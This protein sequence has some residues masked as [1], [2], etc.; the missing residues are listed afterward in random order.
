MSIVIISKYQRLFI[1]SLC[2]TNVNKVDV[3]VHL[4]KSKFK[5][6][7]YKRFLRSEKFNNKFPSK[8]E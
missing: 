1:T 5:I 8:I 2:L 4:L 6:V 3:G 7:L